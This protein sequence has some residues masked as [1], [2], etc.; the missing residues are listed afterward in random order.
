ML[1]RTERR[2]R[3]I[4]DL[5]WLA[6][7]LVGPYLVFEFGNYRGQV[8][9]YREEHA[10]ELYYREQ[11]AKADVAAGRG[12]TYYI[13]LPER[14]KELQSS[15]EVY[16]WLAFVW[17]FVAGGVWSARRHARWCASRYEKYAL[18]NCGGQWW[19]ENPN[20]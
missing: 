1:S 17:V 3:L 16:G 4:L 20:G 5:A 8:N 18:C 6:C 14:L 15:E 11:E 12:E 2:Y 19:K 13:L 9:A 10:Q 7:L